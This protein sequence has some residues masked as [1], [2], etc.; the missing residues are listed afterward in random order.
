LKTACLLI[1]TAGLTAAASSPDPAKLLDD[2]RSLASPGELALVPSETS[3]VHRAKPG[4]WQF[5]LHSYI[6]HYQ[7][8]FW[9]IWS[10]GRVDEDSGQQRIHYATSADGH[11]WSDAAVLA[12]D[13][14]GPDGPALWIARGIFTQNGHLYAL[15]AYNEG[16]RREAQ[17]RESWHNLDLVRFEWD[18]KAWRKVGSYVK[19]CMNNFPPDAVGKHLVMTCRDSHAD[20]SSAISSGLDGS[21]WTV[22]KLPGEAPGDRMSEPSSY[23]DPKGIVHT[24]FRDGRSSK[25]LYHSISHD[26]GKTWTA[27]V[28]TNY[29]DATSKNLTGKLSNGW[30]YLINNPNPKSRDPLAISFS[31]DGWTFSHP[32]ALRKGA[33]ER[34]YAGRSKGS[35]SFQY[36]HAIEHGGSLWVIYSTNKEDIEVSEFKLS[37]FHVEK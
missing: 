7:G 28:R 19:N 10:A 8:K 3:A 4:E 24:I 25:F 14:D 22:T 11:H 29:P 5:N 36:P 13:P 21:K 33:P 34:R 6:A 27:P 26:Q 9:A 15:A 12:D 31:R 20:M 35:G 30:Y 37:S 18:G 16:P 2:P 32:A 1:L 23:V 17:P